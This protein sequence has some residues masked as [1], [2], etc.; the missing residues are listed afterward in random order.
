VG[1]HSNSFQASRWANDYP[2][3][4]SK[5][6]IEAFAFDRGMEPP[7]NSHALVPQF[8]AEIMRGQDKLSRTSDGAKESHHLALEDFEIAE[9]RDGLPQGNVF[10]KR[11]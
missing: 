4:S 9:G 6:D 2:P 10:S 3:R 1:A 7:N 11:V 8:M 5:E